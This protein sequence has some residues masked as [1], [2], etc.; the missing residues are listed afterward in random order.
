MHYAGAIGLAAALDYLQSVGIK[1]INL[2]EKELIRL[3]P[4][5]TERD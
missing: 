3:Y 2:Y 1:E 5:K 4:E